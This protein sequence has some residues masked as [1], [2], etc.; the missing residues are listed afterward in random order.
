MD[1]KLF[2]T[3]T[4]NHLSNWN[5]EAYTNIDD[6]WS[7]FK[8]CLLEAGKVSVGYKTYNSKRDYW[9]KEINKLIKDQ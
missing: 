7:D 3:A 6:M 8:S 9:D 1:W 2:E 5:N 4:N